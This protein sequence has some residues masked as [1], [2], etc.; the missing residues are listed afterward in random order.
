MAACTI[1][2]GLQGILWESESWR[3]VLN[4][5]QNLLGKTMLVLRRHV[6]RVPELTPAEW[7][8]L[9]NQLRE[10]TDRLARAFTP[11]H[12]N[13]AFLQNVDRHV[14]LHV[15]PRYLGTREFAGLIWDDP[16][17]PDRYRAPAAE[18]RLDPAQPDAIARALTSVAA[19]S[20]N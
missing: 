16:E 2:S 3:V 17:Y 12:L 18:R 8:D 9:L 7:S 1:C 19:D 5:N 10:V 15:I 14:H 20:V 4:R 11:D 13:Y 6:E